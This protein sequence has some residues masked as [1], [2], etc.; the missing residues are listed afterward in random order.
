[1]PGGKGPQRGAPATVQKW[2]ELGIAPVNPHLE[3][4][5]STNRQAMG[6]DADPVNL[7]LGSLTMGLVDGYGGLHMSTDLQDVLFGVPRAIDTAYRMGV[8][9]EDHVN[10]AIH[11]HIP[12]LSDKVVQWADRL[13]QE[14]IA[15]GAKG[16][17]VVGVCCTGNEMMMRKGIPSAGS[18]A[19]QELPI[20]TGILEAMVVDCQC[21][22]PSLP[23]IAKCYHTKIIST[24]SYAKVRGATHVDF[25]PETADESAM[26]I[27]RKAIAAFRRRDPK[28]IEVPTET[29]KATVGFSTEQ[30]VEALDAVN[31]GDPLAPLVGA[32]ASGQILGAA[33]IVGCTNPRLKQDWANSELAKHLMKHNVLVLATGCAAHSLGKTGL[34]STD[35]LQYCRDG[36]RSLLETLGQAV[37][38]EA[39]PAALHMGS[40]VDNSRI[41]TLLAALADYL[42]CQSPLCPWSAPALRHIAR[43]PWPSA[44]TS[45]PTAS[46][47]TW[48]SPPRS[49]ARL[50]SSTC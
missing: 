2:L 8:L 42:K 25:T 47:S 36:L 44:A 24:M 1:M 31:P 28:K 4:A 20:I 12:M 10:I 27:V 48:A 16:I 43:R 46:M 35:G 38:L 30:I 17:N 45:W 5:R 26:A 50:W 6:V 15:V 23:E 32:I 19:N 14:A 13:R 37:G 34:L 40:C 29:V 22:M 18:Y 9:R 3:I 41:G 21:V 49:R 7:L 39:L 33:A 11:G